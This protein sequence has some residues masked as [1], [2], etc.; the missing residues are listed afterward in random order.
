VEVDMKIVSAMKE[1]AIDPAPLAA[2]IAVEEL[3]DSSSISDD[4]ATLLALGKKP[5][6]QRVHS[7]WSCKIIHLLEPLMLTS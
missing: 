7:F 1:E 5:E 4:D 2:Q 3:G 6:L